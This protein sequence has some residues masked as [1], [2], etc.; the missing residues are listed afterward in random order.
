MLADILDVARVNLALPD[1]S[2]EVQHN[3]GGLLRLDG[4]LL[5]LASYC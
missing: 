5:F 3:K 4:H 2:C 1:L